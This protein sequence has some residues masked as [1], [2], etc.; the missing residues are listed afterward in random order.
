MKVA[1]L[2]EPTLQGEVEYRAIAAGHQAIAKTAGA[3]L[4]ALTA[5]LPADD[6]GTLV[7]VQ[8]HRPDPFFTAKQQRRL[9]ELMERWRTAR[10][11]DQSLSPAE[12][13]ELDALVDAE[14]RASGQRAAAILADLR[15]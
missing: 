2:P 12:Q 3:A 5:Q 11:S 10:D 8:N 4:D 9:S 14:L 13:V 7:I 15:E 1:I 6:S